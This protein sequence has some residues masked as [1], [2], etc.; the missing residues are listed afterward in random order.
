MTRNTKEALLLVV[1]ITLAGFFIAVGPLAVIWA[2]N[3]LFSLAI[4]YDFF[5]WLAVLVLS[6]VLKTKVQINK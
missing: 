4:S 5:T 1:A 3:T 2:L 6:G